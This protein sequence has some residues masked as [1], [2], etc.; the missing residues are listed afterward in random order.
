MIDIIT[1]VPYIARTAIVDLNEVLT[2]N[3]STAILAR[4]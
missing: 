2:S 1:S 3:E 4:L